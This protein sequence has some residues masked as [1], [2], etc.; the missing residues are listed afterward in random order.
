MMVH[1]DP[2]ENYVLSLDF[3]ISKGSKSIVLNWVDAGDGSAGKIRVAKL[4]KTN[5]DRTAYEIFINRNHTAPVQ[6]ATLAHEL[7][8]L[9]LGHLGD[10]RHSNGNTR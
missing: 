7:G 4:A 2:W 3:K 1:K 9:F 5:K 6:F 10:D 8:H